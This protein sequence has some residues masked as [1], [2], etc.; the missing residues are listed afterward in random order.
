MCIRDR[1]TPIQGAL[2][3]S[4]LGRGQTLYQIPNFD[5]QLLANYFPGVPIGGFFCNGE[6]GPVGKET[7]LHG[8]TSVI[9]LLRQLRI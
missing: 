6:I 1:P 8:Y 4:C 9:A 7:F 3:F 5:S 2:M